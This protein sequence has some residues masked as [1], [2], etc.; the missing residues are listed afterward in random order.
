MS[1]H[2]LSHTVMRNSRQ[3]LFFALIRNPLGT[4][5]AAA[6]LCTFF[7]LQPSP[8]SA[9]VAMSLGS[10]RCSAFAMVAEEGRVPERWYG[11]PDPGE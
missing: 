1:S 5:V 9:A 10:F 6:M 7:S 11:E 4:P 3:L 2:H 8:V